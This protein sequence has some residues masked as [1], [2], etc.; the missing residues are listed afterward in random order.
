MHIMQVTD[1]YDP[2]IGGQERYVATLSREFIRLGHTCV[3]VTLQADGLPGEE[4]IDGVRVIRI[5]SWSQQLSRFYADK[6]R[7]FH[8]TAPD[9]G[10]V[11]ALRRVIQQGDRMS[12]T[13]IVGLHIPISLFIGPKRVQLTW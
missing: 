4:I 12:C 7:P 2:I 5:R 6:S 13:A 10:A 9:P 1:F 8:P 11:K 3:V